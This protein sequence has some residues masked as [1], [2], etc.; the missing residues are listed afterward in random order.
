MIAA[1]FVESVIAQP[2]V[3][4]NNGDAPLVVEAVTADGPYS[5]EP[6]S[7]TVDP[8]RTER[9]QARFRPTEEGSSTVMFEFATNDPDEPSIVVLLEGEGRFRPQPDAGPIDADM[10]TFDADLEADGDFDGVNDRGHRGCDCGATG[11]QGAGVGTAATILIFVLLVLVR[12]SRN[13]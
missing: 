3:F 11:Q 13:H 9:I 1:G 2:L 8:H 10:A 6:S 7:L 5:M 4:I 12:R